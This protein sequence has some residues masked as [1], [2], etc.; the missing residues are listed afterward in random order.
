[1]YTTMNRYQIDY[2]FRNLNAI[3]KQEIWRQKQ[4]QIF[5]KSGKPIYNITEATQHIR[6]HNNPYFYKDRYIGENS[7]E[8]FTNEN[9]DT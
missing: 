4:V 9:K 6:S 3:Q 1:M 8:K 5:Y 7:L 2:E